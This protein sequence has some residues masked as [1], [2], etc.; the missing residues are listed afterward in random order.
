MLSNAEDIIHA[1]TI[2]S[3]RI[4]YK[5]GWNPTK[6]AHSI[7]AFA[8]DIENIG[9]GYIVL[10]VSEKDGCPVFPPIGIDKG[11]IDKINKELLNIANLIEPTYIPSTKHVVIDGS[12]VLIIEVLV[13]PSRPYKCPDSLSKKKS[14]HTG[15][16]YYIR[17]LSSTIKAK[18]DDER[19]LFD[20]SNNVPFDCRVNPNATLADLRPT[21]IYEYISK[22]DPSSFES[23][24]T[25]P[26]GSLYRSLKIVGNPPNDSHPLN[27]GLLFFNED[28]NTY[29]EGA[30]IELTVMPDPS[31]DGMEEI[32]FKG[33]L[34]IQ[35]ERC[36]DFFRT[37]VI[38]TKVIK[39]DDTPISNNVFNYPLRAVEEA[40]S[41]AIYHKDYGI[42]EPIR[43]FVRSDHIMI[44]SIPGPDYSISDAD[45][46]SFEMTSTRY[47]NAR[48]GDLLKHR[49][50]AEKRCTG[51]PNM[52]N[53][54][55]SNGSPDPV[56]DTDAQRSY[57]RVTLPIH[58]RFMINGIQEMMV[59]KT[60]A[61]DN[62]K[63]DV[64]TLIRDNGTL[65][66]R[67]LTNALGYSR[68]AKNLYSVVRELVSEGRIEYT[69][70][71]KI[72][73]RNQRLRIRIQ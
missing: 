62:L 14:D 19:R 39:H 60:S 66:M 12:D 13:G 42:P 29:F 44:Q 26:I 10:G 21:L 24:I 17:K 52:L 27:A 2:E 28:P 58:P 40:I 8:N 67:E 5:E 68:N 32:T 55:R 37:N 69:Y 56:L 57:F 63:Q 1:R 11:S 33:P 50:L 45:I 46:V 31:G 25:R 15:K 30:Y 9:G 6:V 20:I 43:I 4:E 72:T 47:R 36:I 71:D 65:S 18:T 73:S 22:V 35:L 41:N 16:S 7:C 70:P 64:L 34:D 54:M 38:R 53:S 51:I 48:I 3:S 49:G 23:V 61:T 59:D